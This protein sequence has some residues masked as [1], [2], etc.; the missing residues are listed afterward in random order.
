MAQAKSAGWGPYGL[1]SLLS[2][3]Q[4]YSA[5]L[6]FRFTSPTPAWP[7]R[8]T[9]R[10]HRTR[11]LHNQLCL[12]PRVLPSAHQGKRLQVSL[13]DARASFL[14]GL[15]VRRVDAE[16]GIANA[17]QPILEA[18]REDREAASGAHELPATATAEPKGAAVSAPA[19]GVAEPVA[20]EEN[21]A[22][23][24]GRYPCRPAC[25]RGCL[26]WRAEAQHATA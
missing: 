11:Q 12:D 6:H 10:R 15:K 7:R 20:I 24:A 23:E 26:H 8:T 9:S 3:Y 22:A 18:K 13:H 21:A 4:P 14:E 17:R 19:P 5:H 2:G 1:S 16:A 25:G